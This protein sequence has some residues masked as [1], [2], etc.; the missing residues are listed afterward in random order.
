MRFKVESFES[1][2]ELQSFINKHHIE[3]RHIQQIYYSTHGHV[4]CYWETSHF[5]GGKK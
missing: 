2:G 1:R 3:S 4:L 5:H